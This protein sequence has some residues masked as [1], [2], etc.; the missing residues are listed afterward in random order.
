MKFFT[1]SCGLQVCI[2]F[3]EALLGLVFFLNFLT[4]G[5]LFWFFT[6]SCCSVDF[7]FLIFVG[8][9]FG[10]LYSSWSELDSDPVAPLNDSSE[11]ETGIDDCLEFLGANVLVSAGSSLFCL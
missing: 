3:N 6:G 4:F 10:G 5:T 9:F 2:S 1:D 8:L 11:S 7:R